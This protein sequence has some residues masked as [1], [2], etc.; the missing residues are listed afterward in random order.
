MMVPSGMKPCDRPSVGAVYCLPL[1]S[2]YQRCGRGF[3]AISC[4]IF[5]VSW[6]NLS[7]NILRS[8]GI[9]GNCPLI[10]EYHAAVNCLSSARAMFNSVEISCWLRRFILPFHPLGY[11]LL[12]LRDANQ[13]QAHL[14]P[15]S[16]DTTNRKTI[17]GC[18]S[19]SPR[20]G[21]RYIL[22]RHPRS[23]SHYAC[24]REP[25]IYA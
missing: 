4:L 18:L 24:Y 8:P 23:A 9:H 5:R 14:Y 11:L 25:P 12:S 1:H 15:Q 16:N 22:T 7:L 17:P 10:L 13:F 6:L 20:R 19:G 21:I 2:L 3:S